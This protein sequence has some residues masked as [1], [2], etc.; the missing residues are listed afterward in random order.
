MTP[1][2]IAEKVKKD[3][4]ISSQTKDGLI[5]LAV[6]TAKRLMSIRGVRKI[7]PNDPTTAQCIM[8]YCRYYFNF[9]GDA[10]RYF[11]S[12]ESMANS[13]ALAEEYRAETEDS[14]E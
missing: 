11:S 8:L 14:A 13:M 4:H 2:L 3:L 6:E 12:F 10:E 9:Q 5:D 7:D 1:S